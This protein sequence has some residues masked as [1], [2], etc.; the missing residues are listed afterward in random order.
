MSSC[1]L[2]CPQPTRLIKEILIPIPSS[3]YMLSLTSISKTCCT[4][5]VTPTNEGIKHGSYDRVLRRRR[6]KAIFA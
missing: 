5:Y 2:T 3:Q 4:N 6:G 1:R